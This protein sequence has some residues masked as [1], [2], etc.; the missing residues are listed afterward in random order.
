MLALGVVLVG[1]VVTVGTFWL[2]R[3]GQ[4]HAGERATAARGAT[5]TLATGTITATTTAATATTAIAAFQ[6]NS[7]F[8]AVVGHRGDDA[9]EP[10]PHAHLGVRAVDDTT[11]TAAG[12]RLTEVDAG[13]PAASA[14]LQVG[15][16]VTSMAGASITDASDL[17]EAVRS[18]APGDEV[19]VEV[20]RGADALH[21]TVHLG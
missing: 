16:V 1:A 20:R 10:A 11:V 14:G 21:L 9:T 19:A 6:G 12:A 17:L 13:G 2:T 3:P 15:D 8:D 4:G 18:R 7:L 5:T